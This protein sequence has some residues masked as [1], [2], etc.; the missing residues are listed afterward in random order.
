MTDGYKIKCGKCGT[1]DVVPFEPN[2]NKPILCKDCY[3]AQLSPGRRKAHD[4]QATETPGKGFT[5][6]DEIMARMSA[7]R[8][9]SELVAGAALNAADKKAWVFDLIEGVTEYILTGNPEL[10]MQLEKTP[11]QLL[12][13]E[14]RE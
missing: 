12:E 4:E 1:I 7:F 13:G 11:K 9:L 3:Q 5:P 8:G 6:R 2:L 10:R 14:V